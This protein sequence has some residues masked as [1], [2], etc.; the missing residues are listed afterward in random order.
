MRRRVCPQTKRER[1][2]KTFCASRSPRAALSCRH[3]SQLATTLRTNPSG[4]FPLATR[5]AAALKHLLYSSP[6][7]AAAWKISSSS[8]RA[9]GRET[10]PLS[11]PTTRARVGSWGA[12]FPGTIVWTESDGLFPLV[13]LS[14]GVSVRTS[15]SFASFI[16]VSFA[17]TVGV[18]SALLA[19]PGRDSV[20]AFFSASFSFSPGASAV[21]GSRATTAFQSARMAP[22]V[23]ATSASSGSFDF[24]ALRTTRVTSVALSMSVFTACS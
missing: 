24:A 14:V 9:A 11:H 22:H 5:S 19:K 2:N 13:S 4:T 18:V 10:R 3:G 7:V 6:H 23:A 21:P 15:V 12:V 17:G 8:A 1:Q 16:S 20:S